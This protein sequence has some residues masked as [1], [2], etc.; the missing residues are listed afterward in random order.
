MDQK[1]TIIIALNSYEWEK[2]QSLIRRYE[3]N[4]RQVREKQR[5]K[6]K[7]KAQKEGKDK[8]FSSNP[9]PSINPIQI[10]TIST[11]ELFDFEKYVTREY[12]K[13]P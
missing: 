11:E 13:H 1:D 10:T 4:K 2:I 6:A 5:Q 3:N 7:E 8:T 12:P 9:K